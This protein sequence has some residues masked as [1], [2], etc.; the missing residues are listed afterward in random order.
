MVDMLFWF[1]IFKGVF[2]E[3]KALPSTKENDFRD[4]SI[5]MHL[6]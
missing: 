5:K 6:V 2:N 4:Y 3:L 1:C